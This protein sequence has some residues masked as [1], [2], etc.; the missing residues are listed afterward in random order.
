MLDRHAEAAVD[1][2]GAVVPDPDGDTGGV[3]DLADVVR[4]DAVDDDADRADPVLRGRRAEDA[5]AGD[6]RERRRA[7]AR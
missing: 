6:L 7:S 2:L 4:V 3:E 5:D 1:R